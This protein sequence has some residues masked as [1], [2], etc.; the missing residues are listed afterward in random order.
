MSVADRL[1][2]ATDSPGRLAVWLHAVVRLPAR[3]R[4]FDQHTEDT[5]WLL[6]EVIG[7][8]RR[9]GPSDA[10]ARCPHLRLL[11]RAAGDR[12][13]APR[14]GRPVQALSQIA[15]YLTQLDLPD[16]D[17]A[18]RRGRCHWPGPVAAANR[19]TVAPGTLSAGPAQANRK[20]PP[21]PAPMRAAAQQ[22][23]KNVA[24]CAWRQASL[25]DLR[26]PSLNAS[27]LFF[28]SARYG[29]C[30]SSLVLFVG[31]T[32]V[33]LGASRVVWA[34]WPSVADDSSTSAVRAATSASGHIIDSQAVA[35]RVYPQVAPRGRVIS[36]R[37][38]RRFRSL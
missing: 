27:A 10:R 23:S 5:R 25:A 17:E 3:C 13:W 2:G 34:G 9:R 33:S 11:S 18:A 32:A 37:K 16:R 22:I 36:R 4:D 12:R 29:S 8:R 1:L 15:W 38:V 19:K 6:D 31:L 14:P 20:R 26:Q 30:T 24:R 35:G 28:A 7:P 21:R